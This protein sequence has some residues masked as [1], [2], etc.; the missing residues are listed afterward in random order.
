METGKTKQGPI[1]A[2]AFL[3][4]FVWSCLTFKLV[5]NAI[6]M[7]YSLGQLIVLV[8]A[9]KILTVALAWTGSAILRTPQALLFLA[10]RKKG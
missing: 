1:V 2:A 9:V 8:L 10:D 5:C 7:D 3:L 4:A 6:N